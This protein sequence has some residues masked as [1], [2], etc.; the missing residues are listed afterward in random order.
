MVHTTVKLVE[1]ASR[2]RGFD[3]DVCNRGIDIWVI[4]RVDVVVKVP[5]LFLHS[6]DAPVLAR[7]P[8]RLLLGLMASRDLLG[9]LGGL[10]ELLRIKNVG[11][12]E[13]LQVLQA[14]S[15]VLRLLLALGR[16]GVRT[17][18]ASHNAYLG[19]RRLL[20]HGLGLL[21]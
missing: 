9:A 16:G 20:V 2:G 21:A 14:E 17:V 7:V 15:V 3:L 19:C 5:D 4:D 8:L 1:D 13:R 18:R 12:L 10:D 6:R 11:Q